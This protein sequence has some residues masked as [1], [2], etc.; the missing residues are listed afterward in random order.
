MEKPFLLQV[1]FSQILL[2]IHIWKFEVL[3][4]SDKTGE[5]KMI[6]NFSV[7]K[8]LSKTLDHGGGFFLSLKH[9]PDTFVHDFF[10]LMKFGADHRD[11]SATGTHEITNP[12][13]YFR[14]PLDV[15]QFLSVTGTTAES[16]VQLHTHYF[17]SFFIKD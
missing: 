8:S 2:D 14:H 1:R 3:H 11:P 12:L 17:A 9:T 5:I 10:D 16:G 4:F 6:Q 13:V 15:Q 7:Q